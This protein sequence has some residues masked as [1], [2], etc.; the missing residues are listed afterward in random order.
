MILGVS[1]VIVLIILGVSG[2]VF[3]ILFVNR[4][5]IIIIII[6]NLWFRA[7]FFG[8]VSIV[9]RYGARCPKF[10]INSIAIFVIFKLS[11]FSFVILRYVVSWSLASWSGL[12]VVSTRQELVNKRMTDRVRK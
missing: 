6:V 9:V 5:R 1:S 8:L 11:I 12:Q 7:V 10:I 4:F 3:C 2:V